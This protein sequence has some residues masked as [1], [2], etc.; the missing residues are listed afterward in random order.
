MLICNVYAL[1]T[2]YSLYL[3]EHVILNCADTLDL[4]QVMRI[5]AT[6][7]QLVA[8]LKDLIILHLDAGAIRDQICLGL[9]GLFVGDHNLTLFLGIADLSLAAELCND[10]KSLG[11]TGLEKLFYSGK[12]LG[13]VIT[14]HAAGVEG[15][16]G[17]LGTRLTDGLCSDDADCL[18]NLNR[19]AGC[20]VGTIALCADAELGTTGKDRTD[21]YFLDG[22]AILV[23]AYGQDLLCT[24][25]RDHV[26]VLHDHVAILVEDVLAGESSGNT[27]L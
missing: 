21:L 23:N 6:F 14:C 2:V 27:I 4:Q 10:R 19:F 15:S 9:A 16:H 20:H 13:D 1:Q 8:G 18:T 17:Q 7:S 5:Y 24:A 12:T 26:I 22:L 3:A 25:G 11:L